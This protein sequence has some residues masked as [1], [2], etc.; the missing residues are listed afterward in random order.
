MS[1]ILFSDTL[2]FFGA[3]FLTLPMLYMSSLAVEHGPG[4]RLL[5]ELWMQ[6]RRG[7]A[8]SA[9]VC[10]KAIYKAWRQH[11]HLGDKRVD[12]IRRQFLRQKQLTLGF[13]H[14][15][16]CTEITEAPMLETHVKSLLHLCSQRPCCHGSPSHQGLSPNPTSAQHQ[17]FGI[18]FQVSKDTPTRGKLFKYQ[19]GHYIQELITW[20]WR[21]GSVV[22][23]T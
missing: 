16:P 17:G 20:G 4:P 19:K 22:K 1:E 3:F 7:G 18:F 2:P 5:A 13:H 15:T 8:L 12:T 10:L 9:V 6:G 21:D 11:F 23:T 14:T